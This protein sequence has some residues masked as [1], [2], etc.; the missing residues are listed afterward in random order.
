MCVSMR[1]CRL[2][3][4]NYNYML[5]AFKNRS[6][7]PEIAR[8]ET[9]VFGWVVGKRQAL[10]FT[11]DCFMCMMMIMNLHDTANNEQNTIFLLSSSFLV[12]SFKVVKHRN[13]PI[14][15]SKP[16]NHTQRTISVSAGWEEG[17]IRIF[18]FI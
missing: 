7:A 10:L 15:P 14:K 8:F 13:Q 2:N 18:G 17:K 5:T 11:R 4:E 1:R 9:G 16:T 12:G 3:R 6:H